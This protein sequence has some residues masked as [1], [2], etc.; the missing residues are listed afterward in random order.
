M[1]SRDRMRVN[2][3]KHEYQA[4]MT[5]E[6]RLDELHS[7]RKQLDAKMGVHSPGFSDVH[8]Q[9]P[10]SRDHKLINYAEAVEK[11]EDE[12][13]IIRKQT[14]RIEAIIELIPEKYMRVIRQVYKGYG[15][16]ASFC[17]EF[18][19]SRHALQNRID[20]AILNAIKKREPR[21]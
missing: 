1:N 10:Q 6:D 18:N 19:C 5:Y 9:N 21:Y 11:I 15:D 14:A 3:F 2:R 12:E 4:Y 17:G 13:N 16:Y 20:V 7:M 8:V